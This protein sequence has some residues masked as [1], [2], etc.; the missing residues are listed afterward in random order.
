MVAVRERSVGGLKPPSWV[1]SDHS[2]QKSAS[3]REFGSSSITSSETSLDRAIK[4]SA[5]KGHS[6]TGF[7]RSDEDGGDQR[8]SPASGA[9]N[10]TPPVRE[11]NTKK[12]EAPVKY[13]LTGASCH[14]QAEACDV[15]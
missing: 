1:V 7:T 5:G 3:A 6:S 9:S 4:A 11:R 13:E 2:A 12:G 8:T 10:P 14:L 15:A